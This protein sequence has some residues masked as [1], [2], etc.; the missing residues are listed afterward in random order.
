M[1]P[2]LAPR[3]VSWVVPSH[4][5]RLLLLL[6]SSEAIGISPWQVIYKVGTPCAFIMVA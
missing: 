4:S 5:G 2:V 3:Q 6:R 1:K